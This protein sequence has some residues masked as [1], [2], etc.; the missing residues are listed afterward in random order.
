MSCVWNKDQVETILACMIL[1][2]K[3]QPEEVSVTRENREIKFDNY[4]HL[5]N[6]MQNAR[7]D[8]PRRIYLN[9]YDDKYYFYISLGGQGG[10]Y[11]YSS[12]F[13]KHKRI[14]QAIKELKTISQGRTTSDSAVQAAFPEAITVD[15]EKF[16]LNGKE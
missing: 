8:D 12:F 10:I 16:F 3:S 1:R 6:T 11:T 4:K 7:P 5:L 15:F 2:L 13:W 14:K 9:I